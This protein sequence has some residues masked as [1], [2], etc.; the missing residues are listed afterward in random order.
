MQL[1]YERYLFY[2]LLVV[3]P[4][5]TGLYIYT[6]LRGVRSTALLK[7]SCHGESDDHNLQVH[8]SA[9]CIG[10]LIRYRSKQHTYN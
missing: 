10:V 3:P 7:V 4:T 1:L 9:T 5:N 6:M 8:R 2:N